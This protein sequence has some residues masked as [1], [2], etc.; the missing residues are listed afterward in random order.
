MF[1]AASFRFL[2]GQL[3][4]LLF[5]VSNLPEET[6]VLLF[7]PVLAGT[8]LV[9]FLSQLFKILFQPRYKT[10]KK[11]QS[12]NYHIY[13]AISL[14][15]FWTHCGCLPHPASLALKYAK[16]S[17]Y[18]YGVKLQITSIA[19]FLWFSHW[20]WAA[21]AWKHRNNYI[22][23]KQTFF[24]ATNGHGLNKLPLEITLPKP[25]ISYTTNK[26]VIMALFKALL[27]TDFAVGAVDVCNLCRVP[28]VILQVSRSTQQRWTMKRTGCWK[29]SLKEQ[30]IHQI[31]QNTEIMCIRES[32][33]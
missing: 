16:F 23:G 10:L 17:S 20:R 1:L 8:A 26:S 30:N 3:G 21:L 7:L 15:C 11:M 27:L 19:T 29:M 33:F 25:A 14:K 31:K 4:H 32:T 2:L 5:D 28:I 6:L 12:F 24:T 18:A 22:L 9:S 13:A